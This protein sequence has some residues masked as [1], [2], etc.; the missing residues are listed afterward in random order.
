MALFR[1]SGFH[2]QEFRDKAAA[3]PILAFADLAHSHAQR[4][5]PKCYYLHRLA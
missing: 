3:L 1:E 4:Q 2:H 5:D